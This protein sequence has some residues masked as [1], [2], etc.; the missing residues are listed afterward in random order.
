MSNSIP[1][2]D[3]HI[4]DKYR[5]LFDSIDEGYCILQILFDES[6]N[7]ND[8]RYLQVNRAFELNNGLQNAEGKTI[9]ELAPDIE[10]KWIAIY[11]NI[12]QTG[13]ALRFEEDSAALGRIFSLYAF[14]IGNPEEH[15]VAVIFS[16]ITARKK[17]EIALRES[18]HQLKRSLKLRDEFISVASHELKTPVTSIKTYTEVL[19]ERFEKNKDV[20]SAQLMTKLDKQ[21]DRLT[22][23]VNTLLDTNNISD[24]GL[25]LSPGEFDLNELIYEN[26]E[27]LQ[28]TTLHNKI[29]YKGLQPVIVYADRE[30][31][32]QVLTNLVSNAIKYSNE[33]GDINICCKRL[34]GKI[35][36]CISD[37]GIGV[38]AKDQQ[39]IFK[40]FYRVENGTDLSVAGMGLG[41]YISAEIIKK[42]GGEISVKSKGDG[43]G[44]EFCFTIPLHQ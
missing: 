25:R 15:N 11:N 18:E 42:H 28:R 19:L 39:H 20:E 21:V 26:V 14:R 29:V 31:I 5:T 7:A 24:G 2:K 27:Q 1:L 37:E 10:P 33:N 3:N 12:A 9:R 40:R 6:G 8:F 30:R 34:T 38:G 32:S 43:E 17:A 35:E 16:D 44:S 23:L 36:I 41:L 13:E 4:E 22:Q